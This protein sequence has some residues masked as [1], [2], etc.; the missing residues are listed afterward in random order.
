MLNALRRTKH[1]IEQAQ[2]WKGPSRLYLYRELFHR[3]RSSERSADA[4]IEATLQWIKAAQDAAGDGGVS[5]RY[6]LSSGWTSSYPETTGY[7]VPT[8]L[9]LAKRRQDGELLARAERMVSFLLGTQLPNGA[10]PGG[11]VNVPPKP[12]VFNTGQVIQ[13]LVA[14]YETTKEQ[15]AIDAAVRA[16]DWLVQVQDG[17]GSW[18]RFTYGDKATAYH[19]HAAW[20]LAQCGV[21][22]GDRRYLEAASRHVDWLLSLADFSTGWIDLMGFFEDDHSNRR[23]VTHTI[24]YT[25]RGLLELENIL[26]RG[27]CWELIRTANAHLVKRIETRGTLAGVFD[28]E[29][30]ERSEY[31]CLTG[32]VQLAQVWLRIFQKFRDVRFL[33]GALKAIDT[34]KRTQIMD[35]PY[36]ELNGAVAGSFPVWGDYIPLAFPSWA[37]KFLIDALIES[38]DILAELRAD[39]LDFR[40]PVPPKVPL[41]AEVVAASRRI[42]DARRPLK[43]VLLSAPGS[44]KGREVA[45]ALLARGIVPKA[46]VLDAYRDR[47]EARPLGVRVLRK[48]HDHGPLSVL[49]A[50]LRQITDGFDV[51]PGPGGEAAPR[52]AAPAAAPTIEAFCE[53]H[54]I[55][56]ARV[57]GLDS[58]PARQALRDIEPDL[59]VMAGA[60]IVGPEVLEI[61]VLGTI[62][63]HM[64][65]L[66]YFRGM[67]VTEWSALLGAPIG[68]SVHF[69]DKGIDT[70]RIL[71]TAEVDGAGARTIEELRD[72]V[73]RAQLDLLGTVCDAFANGCELRSYKQKRQEGVR[74]HVMHPALKEVLVARLNAGARPNPDGLSEAA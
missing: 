63:A 59:F 71:A 72:R 18:R 36:P 34:V 8:F 17:D 24:A 11:E 43:I 58:A 20:P 62:N 14:W 4:H 57:E 73:N 37:S 70:G 42:G 21:A 54:G 16:A 6:R 39:P 35:S 47:N 13:G 55:P 65:I 33:N 44:A 27:D 48:L 26:G 41:S 52:P 68:A 64:G 1:L 29:W 10:F 51:V 40:P 56:Y 38:Q 15:R 66:P 31:V 30:K 3:A 46:V 49:R 69:V 53:A 23:A 9:E 19:A 25:Y 67:N 7:I 2:P 32:C 74:F 61:P 5:G 28:H 22:T 45:A 60:G 12:V 50:S